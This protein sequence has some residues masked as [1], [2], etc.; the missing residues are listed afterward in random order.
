ML[1]Y[2]L[3]EP[4]FYHDSQEFHLYISKLEGSLLNNMRSHPMLEDMR[5]LITYVK[6]E[7]L[8]GQLEFELS[9]E[10]NVSTLLCLHNISKSIRSLILIRIASL[11]LTH[12]D[13]QD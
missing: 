2:K 7:L 1:L 10:I 3:C 11:F 4:E 13:S 8:S 5:E 6:S 9:F 12:Q